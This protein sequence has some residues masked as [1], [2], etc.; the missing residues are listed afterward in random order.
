M[1]NIL[2]HIIPVLLVMLCSCSNEPEVDA[3]DA[4]DVIAFSA[5]VVFAGSDSRAGF[6]NSE[7]PVGSE[8]VVYGYCIPL[9]TNYSSTADLDAKGGEKGWNA[10]KNLIVPDVLEAARLDVDSHGCYYKGEPGV[11]YTERNQLVAA[12]GADPSAFK[13]S[14]IAYSP[15]SQ[16]FTVQSPVGAPVLN[17][18]VTYPCEEDAMYAFVTDHMRERGAVDMVF[19][20]ILS[21]VSVK[22]NNYS[23][24]SD[25]TVND[26]TLEGDFY[27]QA[28]LDFSQPDPSVTV[29]TGAFTHAR[30]PFVSEPL[31][32]LHDAATTAPHSYFIL[33]N[34]DG[35]NGSFLG[36]GK[37][38]TGS[39]EFKGRT[40]DIRIPREGD[41]FD[42][43]R[44]PRPG[45]NYTLN[46][47]FYGDKI[48][49]MFT[50]DDVEYWQSG[51][52]NNIYI[53]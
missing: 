26:F 24:A 35:T 51:S 14:F 12:A 1:K 18:N 43:G 48:V 50:A 8:F 25:L 27:S 21:A 33:A 17:Y 4:D 16:N 22:F 10:K 7:L 40:I 42:F 6:V 52:D 3:P 37:T 2:S 15:A 31:T 41:N 32:V 19:H 47:N 34:S 46:I 36:A 38:L 11:W 13:Y 45:V 39:F 29:N 20:H 23:A 49:L 30:L 44:I 28:T 53:N 5:P 9:I